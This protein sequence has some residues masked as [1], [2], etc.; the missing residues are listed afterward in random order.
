VG[1]LRL[2]SDEAAA[3]PVCLVIEDA[4]W[5]D[6]ASLQTLAFLARR[7]G[8]DAVAMI[9]AVR[10]ALPELTGSLRSSLADSANGRRVPCWRRSFPDGWTRRS[11]SGSWLR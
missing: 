5:I 11:L 7:I 4:H 1:I 8:A 10:G 9:F 2:I 3:R 6:H